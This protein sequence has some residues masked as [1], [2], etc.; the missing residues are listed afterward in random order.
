MTKHILFDTN[1]EVA[2]CMIPQVIRRPKKLEFVRFQDFYQDF[3]A[4]LLDIFLDIF[5]IHQTPVFFPGKSSC[6][7][8]LKIFFE[9]ANAINKGVCGIDKLFLI[10][11][12]YIIIYNNSRA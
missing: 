6:N 8:A 2:D 10:D 7:T 12:F 4:I 3:R 1:S 9:S 11:I 5:F